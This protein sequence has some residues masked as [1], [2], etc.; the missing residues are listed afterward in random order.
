M[1][2]SLFYPGFILGVRGER[3]ALLRGVTLLIY[4]DHSGAVSDVD[5][6][7]V[8]P[9]QRGRPK[10]GVKAKEVTLF[11]RHWAW[12]ADQK[13]GASAALRKLVDDAITAS[14]G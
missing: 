4:D 6:R 9:P 1:I 12:L 3:D 8:P 10:L 7:D 2:Q 5:L 13:G 11:P 14:H